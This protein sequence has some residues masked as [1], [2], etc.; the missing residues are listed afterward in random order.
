MLPH[1]HDSNF[2]SALKAR[3]LALGLS[4]EKLA[5]LSGLH[6]VMPRRYEEP[7]C[8]E[9]A[10]PK[11]ENWLALNRALGYEVPDQDTPGGNDLSLP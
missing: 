8:G 11:H 7:D 1:P 6:K 4:R 10:R 2:P 9:A 5:E 3:R